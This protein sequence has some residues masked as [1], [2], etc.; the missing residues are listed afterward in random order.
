MTLLTFYLARLNLAQVDH[1]LL[2]AHDYRPYAGNHFVP[3]GFHVTEHDCAPLA[4]LY[5]F[6]RRYVVHELR[7]G[8]FSLDVFD[9][10]GRGLRSRQASKTS[11]Q[12][13]REKHN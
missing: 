9:D 1:A 8:N 4:Q 7:A 6:S 3:A 12:N 10:R 13:N 2:G 5:D 11:E